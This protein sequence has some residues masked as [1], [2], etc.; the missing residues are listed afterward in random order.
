MAGISFAAA[1]ESV[2]RS[3]RL[4]ISASPAPGFSSGP[5][6]WPRRPG[7]VGRN[8]SR[9]PPGRSDTSIVRPKS[10]SITRWRIGGHSR[11]GTGL[12]PSGK[13]FVCASRPATQ[14]WAR[15]SDSPSEQRTQVPNVA[16]VYVIGQNRAAVP[17][18]LAESG[19]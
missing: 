9:L 10:R 14:G 2:A 7:N 15:P 17:D 4:P 8:E 12:W 18:R 16:K 3:K 6:P 11:M 13:A 5:R 1:G 19:L